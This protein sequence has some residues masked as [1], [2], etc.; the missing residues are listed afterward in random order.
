MK[1]QAD[2]V[3]SPPPTSE[4]RLNPWVFWPPF[5]LF[6]VAIVFNFVFPDGVDDLG[7]KVDG[8]FSQCVKLAN[9]WVLNQFGWLFSLCA[10][11]A[12]C[13]C[14]LICATSFWRSGFAHVR[15]G[16][17]EAKPLLSL[18]NW[19]A[20]TVCTTI[21]IGILFWSTAEPIKHLGSPP[22]FSGVEP[23]S[24]QAAVFSLSTMF[25]HWSFTPYALYCVASLMFAFAY[26]NMKQPFSLGS[27]VT[28]ILGKFSIGAGG[29]IID[30]VCL[31]ALVAGMAA[32]LGT[33]ILM[34]SGGLNDMFGIPSNSITWALI[35]TTIV[36]TFIVSS[37]TGLMK[38]IRIL[39]DINTKLLFLLA[40]VPLVF[41][42]AL[43]IV[44]LGW[45]AVLDYLLTFIPRN[46]SY[47]STEEGVSILVPDQWGRNW[48]V[49]YWAVW[50]AWAPITACFLGR[51]A[52]GRTV[53][54]FMLVN[55]LLPSLFA[56]VW[57]TIFSGT[58]IGFQLNGTVDLQAVLD[59]DGFQAISYSVFKQFPF[60][61]PIILFYMLSAFICFVTSSDSNMSAMASISSTGIS[62]ENPE[63][64]KA[65]K[66]VW[67]I[68]VGA[69]AWIMIS[70]TGNVDG[71][72]MLSNLGGFPAAFLEILIIISLG[73]TVFR[74]QRLT[75][76]AT[77]ESDP[78][79]E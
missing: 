56:M 15:I 43:F 19:F 6:F 21:A 59:A 75:K 7:E 18:W 51:I 60:A 9:E 41:G 30:A 54:E 63:G 53:K 66:I 38:G 3:N 8:L 27:T 34:L 79:S 20:I 42:P 77:G 37:A 48:T 55:F 67:G 31:Y 49:F 2:R 24:H 17:P 16:G 74:H 29:W 10:A 62:P 68:S 69:V 23:N 1:N 45:E 46:L 33:G 76:V 4:A 44:T 39:S 64:S 13:L 58:A 65:L 5:L 40:I 61:T 22:G 14:I 71:V 70:F 28:P 47:L 57:M 52:Y 32:A 11:L 78:E 36:A 12:L 72:K 25:L 50:I 73:I 26:Y 35:A